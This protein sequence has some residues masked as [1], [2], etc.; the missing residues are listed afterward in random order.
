MLEFELLGQQLI[1]FM[2][3]ESVTKQGNDIS[4]NHETAL[5]VLSE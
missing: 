4:Q 3:Q 5:V 2:P 1:P